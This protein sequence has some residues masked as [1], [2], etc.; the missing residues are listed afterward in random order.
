MS[1][2]S[3]DIPSVAEELQSVIED[4]ERLRRER[5]HA[6]MFVDPFAKVLLVRA[7]LVAELAEA[8][9]KGLLPEV[10]KV[11]MGQGA[12][13]EQRDAIP[14]DE[15]MLR[16]I[17]EALQQ[18][19]LESFPAARAD[20]MNIGMAADR[21]E[22]FLLEVARDMM[23]DR[24]KLVINMAHTFGVD[25]RV[26]GFWCIQLLTPLAMARGRVLHDLVPEDIWNRGYCPVCGSWPSLAHRHETGRDLTCSF[27]STTWHYTADACPFCDAEGASGQVMALPGNQTERLVVCSNCRQ[28]LGEIVGEPFPGM[29]PEVEALALA[30]LELLAR[31]QGLAPANLDWRQMLWL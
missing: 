18:T 4:V 16:R 6:A 9:G 26:M 14:M 20:L 24:Q 8:Y 28:Y 12:P 31:Q 25:A 2:N 15:A 10:D 11:R 30:P 3:L 17:F 29:T 5:P 21:K 7:P 19:L 23:G 1:E 13:L 22:G 27:C